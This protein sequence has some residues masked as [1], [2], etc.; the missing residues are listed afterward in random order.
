ML[1]AK[2]CAVRRTLGVLIVC[3][4]LT[5]A[6]GT[7][8]AVPS[9]TN[10][11]LPTPTTSTGRARFGTWRDST[12]RS[13]A[14]ALAI[15]RHSGRFGE[16]GQL[17]REALK[18]LGSIGSSRALRELDLT[19]PRQSGTTQPSALE[20][21]AMAEAN[22][23]GSWS[24]LGFGL[25][26]TPHERESY[27]VSSLTTFDGSLIAG[28]YFDSAGTVSA[29]DVAVWDGNS[30]QKLGSGLPFSGNGGVFLGIYN[31]Q[32]VAGG[33]NVVCPRFR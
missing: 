32:L 21:A 9:R 31:N 25:S 27:F 23:T 4:A 30:W 13:A 1:T 14:R 12:A 5:V 7:D 22:Y 3:S 17:D 10:E 18:A 28:G 8:A 15:M 33:A 24:A 2:E 19:R 11:A 20:S 6:I 16:K 26:L 29:S